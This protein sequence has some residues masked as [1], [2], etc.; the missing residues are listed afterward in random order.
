M[1][2]LLFLLGD[3]RHS[4]TL[5]DEP[6]TEGDLNVGESVP[7]HMKLLEDS[8]NRKNQPDY[9][10]A[11]V[12]IDRT[13]QLLISMS[14]TI[15]EYVKNYYTRTKRNDN[16][17]RQLSGFEEIVR[18]NV[19]DKSTLLTNLL[20]IEIFFFSRKKNDILNS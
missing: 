12:R 5:L 6:F 4:K 18:T 10:D 3:P 2:D 8:A 19:I 14:I 20:N 16:M 15:A 7:S 17:I 1:L 11:K 9:S 13:S